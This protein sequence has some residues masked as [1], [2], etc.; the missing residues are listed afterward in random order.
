MAEKRKPKSIRKWVR[1]KKTEIRKQELGK[2]PGCILKWRKNTLYYVNIISG[3]K[4]KIREIKV[5]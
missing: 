5:L 1:K 3:E 4:E 2:Y